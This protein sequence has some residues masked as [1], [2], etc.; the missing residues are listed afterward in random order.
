MLHSKTAPSLQWIRL[1]AM[2]EASTLLILLGVAVPLKHI[3]DM[4]SAVSLMGPIHGL[5]F[6]AYLW[7]CVATATRQNWPPRSL[8]Y[9]LAAGLIPFGGLIVARKLQTNGQAGGRG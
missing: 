9:V 8:G 4:P 6:M 2:L 3:Y 7:L 1:A 5:V